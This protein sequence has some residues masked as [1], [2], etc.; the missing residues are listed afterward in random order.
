M[1]HIWPFLDE[2]NLYLRTNFFFVTPF[3]LSSYFHTLPITLLLQILGGRIHGTDTWA[4]PHLKFWGDRPQVSAHGGIYS[5]WPIP[6]FPVQLSF[7]CFLVSFFCCAVPP[8][9]HFEIVRAH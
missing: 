1:Y 7:F 3:L 4:V 2:K 8:S 5:S 9:F 6:L